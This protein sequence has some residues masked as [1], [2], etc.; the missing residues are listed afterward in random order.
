M[1]RFGRLGRSVALLLA[2]SPWAIAHEHAIAQGAPKSPPAG[3]PAASP[4]STAKAE[5]PGTRAPGVDSADVVIIPMR[6]SF[7]YD[8]GDEWIDAEAFA[9]MLRQAKTLK[10]RFIVLDI[11]SPGG[12]VSVMNL[13]ADSILHELPKGAGP[14]IVAWPGMAGSAASFITLTCPR[15]VVK[16][17]AR[18]GA[19]LIVVPTPKGMVA[20]EDLPPTSDSYSA[21]I[22]SFDEAFERLAMQY[23]GHPPEVRQAMAKRTASLY[24]SPS[25]GKFTGSPPDPKKPGD[26]E[27]LDDPDNV[28]TLTAPEALRFGIA[29]SEAA[30]E[31]SLLTS[32]G[33]DANGRI[34][35]LGAELPAWFRQVHEE[36]ETVAEACDLDTIANL[37][38]VY[39]NGLATAISA[40]ADFNSAT[41]AL[42]GTRGDPRAGDKIR[43]RI[44]Q[45]TRRKS[46][47]R[48]AAGQAKVSLEN[49]EERSE[50]SL[51]RLRELGAAVDLAPVAVSRV[52]QL[53]HS[54]EQ[55]E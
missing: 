14:T 40:D 26:F 10:P 48:A 49:L 6:G 38:K 46:E 41:Q 47:A 13:V 52:P 35:R 1:M 51:A 44:R 55:Y 9:A 31:R 37:V 7:G 12:R 54:F 53:K 8:G 18:I 20:V 50:K 33:I 42:K 17:T 19:A 21:K 22:R 11:E 25:T 43:E 32:L 3:Q 24:W 4:K 29:S 23:G 27:K 2:I 15:I 30:D 45:A 39:A 16:P 36:V 5:L 28:L 34:V